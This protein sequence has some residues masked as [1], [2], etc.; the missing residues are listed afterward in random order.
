MAP[1]TRSSGP[2]AEETCEAKTSPEARPRTPEKVSHPPKLLLVFPSTPSSQDSCPVLTW[3]RPQPGLHPSR[4][5]SLFPASSILSPDPDRAPLPKAGKRRRAGRG[6]RGRKKRA[7]GKKMAAVGAPEAGSGPAP[8]GPSEPPSQELPPLEVHVKEE[9]VS[10]PDPLSQ[11]T[12]LEGPLTEV[13]FIS[14]DSNGSD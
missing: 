6:G 1:K 3:H 10:E 4:E 2:P 14:S 5:T 9:P 8:P 13:I 7:T 12:Q 11:E